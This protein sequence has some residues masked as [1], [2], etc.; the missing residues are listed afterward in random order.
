[1][2]TVVLRT[3][4][5]GDPSFVEL[6]GRV[7]EVGLSAFEH[8]DVPFERLVEELAPARS[9][10]RHPLTQV[11]LTLK[12]T[13][14]DGPVLAG[15]VGRPFPT[16]PAAARFD[17]EFNVE[18]RRDETGS[19][20]GLSG[21]LIAAADLFD[22]D[23]AQR[24]A[25]WFARVLGVLVADVDRRV[26][27][28]DVLDDAER[29]QVLVEWNPEPVAVPQSSVSDLF[30]ARVAEAPAAVAVV[31]DG[32]ELTYGELDARAGRLASLLV[33]HGVGPES[34]VG[35]VLDRGPD[36]LVAMLAVVRAGGA[37]VPVDPRYP[38]ERVAF[39]ISDAAPVVVLAT[40]ATAGTWADCP[41]P[42]IVLDDAEIV[43]TVAELPVAAPVAVRPDHPLY[44]IYT[45]GSTGRPKG[46]TVTHGNLVGMFAATAESFGGFAPTDVWSWFHSAAFD[47]SVWELWGA[48]L[49][50][51]RVVVVPFEVSRSP[52]EFA[53]LVARE[54][55]T[56]LSQTPS[57]FYEVMDLLDA[58]SLRAVVFGGEALNPGRLTNWFARHG[59]RSPRL[60]NM[61]GITETTVHVTFEQVTEDGVASVVGQALPGLRVFVL[62]DRLR[63]VPPGVAGEVYVAGGQLARGYLGRAGLTG[64]RFVACPFE[65]GVRMYRSGDLARFNGAGRLEFLGRADDQVKIRGFRIELG[66]VEAAVAAVGSV[67]QAA[68]V[69]REDT[70]GDARLLAYV[71]PADGVDHAGLPAVVRQETARRLPGHMVPA[72]VMVIDALPLTT[73]GKLDRERLP[74]PQQVAVVGRAPGNPREEVVCAGF[75]ALLGVDAVG[76]DDDFFALGGHSLLVVRLVEWLR[77]RGVVVPVRAFFQTP[78]PAG[79]AAATG[80][81]QVRVPA[82]RIPANAT[83]ITPDMLPL[84]SLTQ[85][86]I[87]RI[88]AAVDGGAANIADVYPLAPLQEG[89]LFHHLLAADGPD[90]YVLPTILHFVDR[91]L[92]DDFLAA[93][94]QVVDRHDIF[95][96]ALV[97]TGLTQPVQAVLRHATVPVREVVAAGPDDLLAAAG[98]TIDLTRA[99]LLDATVAPAADGQWLALIRVHHVVQDHTGLDVL[100][101]EVRTILAGR[102]GELPRPLP[103]RDF[104]AQ[105]RASGTE[106]EHERYFTALLGDVDEPTAA[107]GVLDVRGDGTDQRRA[108]EPLDPTL[109]ERL[110]RVARELGTSPATILHTAWART[111]AVLSG[112]DD[113]VFG[114]VLFGRMNAGSGSDRVPGPFIN[115]L[116]VRL[117][118]RRLGARAA[119][120]AMR[121]QLAGLLEHE[122]APLAVA[123]RVSGVPADQPLFTTIFNY[124][125]NISGT[126]IGIDGVTVVSSREFDNF[127]LSVSVDDDAE[128]IAFAVDAAGTID[129]SAVAALLHTAT[130]GLIDAL[131]SATDIRLAA[132]EVLPADERYRMLVDWNDTTTPVAW[133]SLPEVFAAQVAASPEATAVVCDGAALSFAE[134]DGRA[135]RLARL[136]VDSGIVRESLVGLLLPRGVDAVVA[137][138]AVLKAGA[139][140]LPLDQEYPAERIALMVN[141]AAPAVVLAVR[142][143]AG[144]A[145]EGAPVLVLDDPAAAAQWASA[146]SGDPSVPVGP[147]SVAYVIYTSGSTGRP[148]GV[149]VTHGGLRNLYAFH[150]SGVMAGVDGQRLRFA[151]TASLSFD[152]SW[153]GLLW[154]VA[155]HELHVISD[156]VRR[157]TSAMVR[158]VAEL[159]VGVMDV[160]P[161]YAEQLVADGLLDAPPDILLLGGEAVGPRL[162]EQLRDGEGMWFVPLYGPTEYSVD[163]LGL[164]TGDSAGPLVGVPITNTRAYV[165]DGALR[166]VPIGVAG[167]LYLAGVGVARGYLRQP[168][169]SGSRFVACPFG[170]TGERMYRTGDV[171]R[172]DDAGRLEF[173]GRADGQVKIRGFRIEL[174]EVQAAVVAH[175][176]IVRAAVVVHTDAA[177][178]RRLVAYVVA[179]DGDAE[180]PERVRRFVAERLP[181][182]MV[183]AA[184]VVLD[185]LPL[186]VNGKLDERALPAPDFAARIGAGGPVADPRQELLCGVFAEVLGLPAVGVDDDFFALGGHSLLAVRL[187]GRLRNVLGAEVTLRALFDAPTPR[188]FVARLSEAGPARLPLTAAARSERAPL[189]FAQRRLWFL[190]RLEGP[191]ATYNLP[192]ALRLSGQIDVTALD[193][194]LRDVLGRHE[195]L[196]TVFDTVDGETGQRVLPLDDLDWRL[197]TVEVGPEALDE[198]I[199]ELAGRPF[200]LVHEVPVRARLF[201]TAPDEH[202]LLLVVH[203]IASDGWS[204]GRLARDLSVAY[205]ARCAGHAPTWQPLPVQY[206]DYALWQR[207]L[208]GDERD[209]G[210]LLSTQVAYWR[211]ALAGAPEELALPYDHARPAVAGHRGHCATVEVPADLHSR[212]REL[213]RAE[214]VTVSMVLQAAVAVLLSRLGAGTDIPIGTATAGRTDEALDDLVGFFVNTVV[215][216]TDLSGNPTVREVLAH[217]R[218]STLAGLGNQDVPFERLVEE[219]AP[220]RS[221]A[222]HPL[223]Q[224]MLTLQNNA[225]ATL[226]LPGLRTEE[227][228]VR[229]TAAKFDLEFSLAETFDDG[230]EP[231][232][233]TGELVASADLFEPTSVVQLLRRFVRV[234]E[235]LAHD[236]GQRVSAID[237]LDVEE[238]S[239][240][241]SG[242]NDTAVSYPVGDTVVSLFARQVA[243][244]PDAVAVVFEGVSVSYR[245]LD[246]RAGAVAR[247][248]RSVGVGRESVVGVR[249]DRGVDLVVALV[250][251]L[252]AGGAYL[253]IDPEYPQQRVDVLVADAGAAVVLDSVAGLD[254]PDVGSPVE[255]ASDG[256]AYVLFTSGSTGRPKG[257]VVSH[258]GVVNRLRWMQDRFG[259][260]VGERVVQKTPFTFDVSVWEF[261]WP[262]IVGATVV[263]ARPGGHRDPAYLAELIREERVSTAHFVPSMLE[264]FV[265]VAASCT[266]LSRVVCSGEALPATTRDSLLAVLPD[267]ELHNLY[268]PTEASVDVTATRCEVGVPVTIGSPVANTR[269]YVLDGGLQPVPVGAAGELY[270]AGVQLARGYVGRAGLTAERFVANPFEPGE[271]MY[272]TGDL[273]RWTSGGELDYLGRT[274]DQV[275]IRGFRIE[276]GEVQAAVVAHPQVTQ[277]AVVVRGERLVAYVVGGDGA[278]VREFV[279]QRLPQY[280]VPAAVVVLDEL[281]LTSSG[282]LDRRALPDPQIDTG[283]GRAPVNA[284]EEL[285]CAGFAEV[286]GLDH[287][288]VEDDFFALGGHS[289]VVVRLVEWLRQR[290]VSVPVRAF[291]QTPT[292]AALAATGGVDTVEVPP[293]L[294]PA[295]TSVITPEMLPL[296]E[297]TQEQIDRITTTVDGGAANI[298]DIYPL[299]PLQEGI[300][301]HHLLAE[302]GDEAYIRPMVLEMDSR[303]RLDDFV[304]ALQMVI[305]RHDIYRTSIAWEGLTEPVQVVRRHVELRVDDVVLPSGVSDP[306]V[307]LITATGMAMPLGRAPLLDLSVAQIPGSERWLALIRVHHMVEDHTGMD[308]ALAELKT[309]LSGHGNELPPALPFRDFVAKTRYSAAEEEHERYFRTLLGDVDEPTAPFGVT[310][311]LGSGSGV[312]RVVHEFPPALSIQ[313]R[314]VS[315]Q[316]GASPATLLHVA[317]ARVLAALSGRYDVVFATVLF[318]RMNAGAGSDRVP[319]PFMNMLP[320]RVR[321]DHRGASVAVSA[322]RDQLA[323]LMEHE[324]AP[325]AVAQRASAVDA[326]LPLFTSIFNYRH[327]AAVDPEDE[328]LVGIRMVHSDEP[329]N[330]PL[331]VVVEDDG[332]QL[333]LAIDAV[334]PIDAELVSGL[335][336]ATTQNLVD[337]LDVALKGGPDGPLGE[338]DVFDE[339]DHE[340]L[341]RE[342][343]D[344]SIE[345]PDATIP[346]L[347]ERQVRRAPDAPAVVADDG[348]LT[349]VELDARAERLARSLAARGVG[350]ESLVA[351]CMPRGVELTVALLGVL[352][353]GGAYLP[354]DPDYPV[355]RIAYMLHDAQPPVLLATTG[356]A[357]VLT[358]VATVPV[359]VTDSAELTAELAAW[360]PTTPRPGERARP[361]HPA[362]VIYTSGS[363]GRPK[364]VLVS[365]AGVPSLV[366]GHVTYL[367][368]G[369]GCRVGQFASASFDTFGW[370]WMMALLTGATLVVI[371]AEQR[372]GTALPAFLAERQVTHVTLPP[373]VLATLDETSIAPDVVL[374]VAGEACPLDVLRRWAPGRRMFNSYGPTETTVDA[375]LWRFAPDA[376]EVA[377]GAPVLNSR[378][379]IL[380]ERLIP[381]PV[382]VAGEL[383]LA[384]AGLARGYVGRAGLTAER[385]VAC[386]HGAAG[387][388]MYRTGDRARWTADGDLVFAGR[389][390]DQVKIRGFRIEPGEI[391][392]VLSAHPGVAQAAVVVREDR[393]GD[394]RLVGYLVP[395]DPEAGEELPDLIRGLAAQRLPDYMVPSALVLMDALPL[396][397]NGKL[398]RRALPAPDLRGS[399]GRAP[400]DLREELICAAFAELLGVDRVGVDDDFFALGGQSL[401]AVRLVSRLRAMLGVEVEI[402]VL[403]EAPTPA[404]LA[405]RLAGASAARLSLTARPRPARV[406]LSYAQRRLWFIDQLEP[407]ATYNMPIAVRLTGRVDVPALDGALRDLIGR[408]EALRT[409]FPTVDGEPYQHILDLAE[410]NWELATAAVSAADLPAAVAAAAERPFDLAVEPPVRASLLT[411]GPYDHVLVLV[412]HH[413]AGDGWSRGPLARDLS[414]AYG[415]RL[416]GRSPDWQ[417]L[418]VQYADYG[419]WQREL[420]GA[421]DDPDSLLSRQVGYWRSALDGVPQELSLPTDQP[422]PAVA[423]HRGHEVPVHLPAALHA[424]LREVT[425]AEG[426]TVFMALQAALAVLLS[427]L[428]AG[429]DVPIGSTS[430]GRTDVALDDLVGFFVNTVVTR[431]DLS[432]DPAFD[433]V[434]NRVR[435]AA[436]A[437]LANQDVPF[438]RLVEELAPTRSLARHPLFQVMLTVQN[439]AAAVVDLPDVRVEEVPAEL[440]VAKF[441]LEVIVAESFDA[442]GA[443]AGLD[444]VLIAAADLFEA[445]TVTQLARRFVRTVEAV[446]ADPAVRVGSIDVFDP[447]ERDRV[448]AQWNDT[449]RSVPG[450]LVPDLIAAWT[451][452]SPDAVAVRYDDTALSYAELD[453]RAR[454]L[455]RTLRDAGAGPETV[456][457]LCLPRGVDVVVAI[458]AAW[459]AGAAYLPIDPE[460]PAER[461]AYLIGDA[462]PAAIVTDQAHAELLPDG[463]ARILLDAPT[464][465]AG[466]YPAGPVLSPAN[467]AYVIYTSGS[468]GRPKGVSVPHGGLTNLVEVFRSVLRVVPGT[469]VLQFASFSFDA[470]VLDLAVTL[471]CGGT[472]VVA[473]A[474]QR[475]EPA[476][477]RE[478]VQRAGIRS[479]S[480]VPSLLGVLSPHDLV[481][482]ESMV[483]GSEGIEP[484]LVATWARGRRLTHA[485]GPTEATVIVAAGLVDPDRA[486]G[487]AA[488]PFG[489]PLANSRAYVLDGALAPVPPGVAGELYVAGDQLARG[490]VRRPGLTAER[491]VSCPHGVAGERMYRTGDLVRWTADGELVFLGRTD[492][493]VKLR[494]FRIELGEVQAALAAHP[495]VGQAV[496]T[497]REDTAGDRRLVGYVVPVDGV[498]RDGLPREVRA[499]VA[500]TLPEYM[501][502]SA[503][504]L[505]DAIPLTPNGK[506]DR[507]ALPA[508]DHVARAGLGRLPVTPEEEAICAVFAA[509]LG[510]ERVTADDDFFELGGHSLLAIDVIGRIRDRLGVEVGI[511]ELFESP[512]PAG[513]AGRVGAAAPAPARPALRPMRART[514]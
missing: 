436:L 313:V 74:V 431:V 59:A 60:V 139:G 364:G 105:A 148:K 23:T 150:R 68:V 16:G 384:G 340:R 104:V 366:A 203:H 466:V 89:L 5:S 477:L 414:A 220:I 175:Q 55:V 417:P 62:D 154:M 308:V 513:L 337:T 124:R 468:T 284:R 416:T 472:L 341:L 120:A 447:A 487:G 224:T 441:D 30:A 318:G 454:R 463:T 350:P 71:V 145:P 444:G 271:R 192:E 443:P 424:R 372:L 292:P 6:L 258:A 87:D 455:A 86:Q 221:L 4:V 377:I 263:V 115:T 399:V 149:V 415:A 261:F 206:A 232:G 57:A 378:A 490:Y 147:D 400:A 255:V 210:S 138:L 140:Y 21:R 82:N 151:L 52:G 174:G 96:T 325:L 158:Y 181:G 459:Q 46:V 217:L 365:H 99:P 293:N 72:V 397:S 22:A 396:T 34:L 90:A 317:W 429:A 496:A 493:Q 135:N 354:V 123:Q 503:V 249:M 33:G 102:A 83:R 286:L 117:D 44:V 306:V 406:P 248:L 103:F 273:V 335:L 302:G 333:A 494:G 289:L 434:L 133:S 11:V 111:L 91:R 470:S 375:T 58:G 482:V 95:R 512:T 480:V 141:D 469:P 125:H 446:T 285:L 279:G 243:A 339:R 219:L 85:R 484:S 208:L 152:T 407:G 270:L 19:P 122:H 310:D 385:F 283:V 425:R 262:L 276:L 215:L 499:A 511:R 216:R 229:S 160:T 128:R 200:D 264:A 272:R 295:D 156:E 305:D 439:N 183:P 448:L 371:P 75:A 451:V 404:G 31:T 144:L 259:L 287:V 188:A 172:W 126:E 182:H 301:F 136:L 20:A 492:D 288:G 410:M 471:A 452:A 356:T 204:V 9:M 201:A 191:N 93:L 509:A 260:L 35:L 383:Y 277:A 212:L 14:E 294:I 252:K 211:G 12:N 146:P 344:T 419:L 18:E 121:D 393:P 168:G 88:A 409:V 342:W 413:I 157:D 132:V 15:T 84:V 269:T 479:A 225:A 363:T 462:M 379:F 329:T 387:E 327:N 369:A 394:K 347:F 251:V 169:L 164:P 334:A 357:G 214:G 131:E 381:V 304:A 501:V 76:V 185:D 176:E 32:E 50:G 234:L 495:G 281:P 449:G 358:D 119:V 362:Y 228:G 324:H 112:R 361:D 473:T 8:Q 165:L 282:K 80:A 421:D 465:D 491:F 110:R 39:T 338:V 77:R 498:D 159:G 483:V 316:L 184:V 297:L 197:N 319:G 162:W 170:G 63:P 355:E 107:Y 420:L 508:P 346:E 166:P 161:T 129:P 36:L 100:L 467:A 290:G 137:I 275:K 193:A 332:D 510:L 442:S 360:E 238:R 389:A 237:V 411:V 298:A 374:V 61:Y 51:G 428:G 54:R 506:L 440:S 485:Y 113:V 180:L 352:K 461:I 178:D 171:V 268:G 109:T 195:I 69:V 475:A 392:A 457:G 412:L 187:L 390:D 402:R 64:E 42:V 244:T 246:V 321:I 267:T 291:F 127:P 359:L 322:M 65:P 186:T 173:L 213:A 474:A 194:A 395:V 376:R 312:A 130:E 13:T 25:T 94:Q 155:G 101:S 223:F 274:D 153:E 401:L 323:E 373:A 426:A 27:T 418:P 307:E 167:E 504:V 348:E 73:N 445:E 242:W 97:W 196:R 254:G 247:Y 391:A 240:V 17:L 430:A 29:R 79:L 343:N 388:R 218:D 2:N 370:E 427:R 189:S 314:D 296:V 433:E 142:A 41:A 106:Q 236:A 423:S 66:E 241:L 299:A 98:R 114:T 303:P 311:V 408:H 353:A 239:L 514:D 351:V 226:D 300:L 460:Q 328:A 507:R 450:T 177:G 70:P 486:G 233:L 438:E 345:V 336:H 330:Y 368:V 253:P 199:A 47:F 278:G 502:P 49:H 28:I 382:G 118:T 143:T 398:D 280:M 500:A 230:G 56:V 78:T 24:F 53:A 326:D 309:I 227:Y 331:S 367:D 26:S 497:L 116:P 202:V 209:P 481:G 67:A 7:R 349:Y 265:P 432:G 320:V 134:L 92:L 198:A 458:V 235:L 108:E 245:E 40:T 380:D 250:G 257:V 453:A 403:F 386:P 437:G 222:R 81:R 37:Y 405:A 179:D 266:G 45:S 10:A 207:E 3:D 205:T 435:D 488:V 1:M 478:L 422:R 456:V 190:D 231:A 163:A 38:A 256:A 464:S 489:G 43:A 476:L 505:V 315:Q 48:L